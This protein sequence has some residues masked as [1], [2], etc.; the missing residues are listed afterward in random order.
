MRKTKIDDRFFESTRG[1]IVLLLRLCDRTVDGLSKELSVSDNA[2][3]AHLLSLERDGLVFQNG[4]TKGFRKPHFSYSLSPAAEAFFP[5]PFDSLFTETI[6]VLKKQFPVKKVE[7]ILR[8]IGAEIAAPYRSVGKTSLTARIE[9]AIKA[10]TD[11]GGVAA[12][13]Q[14][15][16]R[17]VISGKSCPLATAVTRHKEV[18]K[19]AESLVGE[20]VERDVEETCERNGTAKCRFE[21]S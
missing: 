4:V 14:K 20:I 9:I 17:V 18:C 5:K 12:V 11:I 10:L 6:G 7:Q 2:V 15:N 1:K 16:G 19:L 13:S 21:I 3:R 8:R